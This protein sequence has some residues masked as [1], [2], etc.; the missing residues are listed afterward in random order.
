[1]C[2]DYRRGQPPRCMKIRSHRPKFPS[3]DPFFDLC[4]PFFSHSPLGVFVV[5]VV[6]LSRYSPFV[7]L[8]SVFPMPG[9]IHSHSRDP[10]FDL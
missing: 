8:C 1:L 3:R 5:F 4:V 6:L 9:P 7:S 2:V 10:F